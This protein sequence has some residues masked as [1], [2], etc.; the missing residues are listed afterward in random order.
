MWYC[1]T[2]LG[3]DLALST[4]CLNYRRSSTWTRGDF[5]VVS[6]T[7]CAVK[8]SWSLY[9]FQILLVNIRYLYIYTL[10]NTD[11][12]YH[13]PSGSLITL[14][15][16]ISSQM[17]DRAQQWW[18]DSFPQPHSRVISTA[19]ASKDVQSPCYR[20]PPGEKVE[21]GS[22]VEFLDNWWFNMVITGY[23]WDYT[24]YK[25]GYKYL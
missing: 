21:P 18:K 13:H 23:K 15:L 14:H 12:W 9:I 22:G 7:S 2:W 1:N 17:V 19:V 3:T 8:S 5:G 20:S 6:L 11:Y 10:Y 16:R 24:F 4:I 25:W